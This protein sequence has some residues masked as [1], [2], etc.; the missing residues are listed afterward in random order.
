MSLG[1]RFVVSFRFCVL[2]KPVSHRRLGNSLPPGSG[3]DLRLVFG[4]KGGHSAQGGVR[5]HAQVERRRV[6]TVREGEGGGG[7]NLQ[8]DAIL[9]VATDMYKVPLGRV[10]NKQTVKDRS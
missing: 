4:C 2:Y 9:F 8:M 3:R 6:E 10:P 5:T 1:R 7:K